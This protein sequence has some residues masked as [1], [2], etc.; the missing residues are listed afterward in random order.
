MHNP[1][2]SRKWICFGMS[3][4]KAGKLGYG[5]L[6]VREICIDLIM[7]VFLCVIGFVGRLVHARICWR[8][9]RLDHVYASNLIATE[10]TLIRLLDY[11]L[12]NTNRRR[13]WL[14]LEVRM[15]MIWIARMTK[16]TSI[17]FEL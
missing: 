11:V 15:S 13:N 6:H 10:V 17:L 1:N 7:V 14:K 3:T 4:W 8:L 5:F 2:R 16:K 12:H 9:G